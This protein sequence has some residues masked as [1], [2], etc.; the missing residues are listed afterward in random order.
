MKPIHKSTLLSQARKRPQIVIVAPSNQR[1]L[2][3]WN[4]GVKGT[5]RLAA[6]HERPS[7]FMFDMS[8]GRSYDLDRWLTSFQHYN[9][10]SETGRRVKFWQETDNV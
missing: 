8:D 7:K 4:T 1:P 5:V 6:M 2:T 10:N 3:M 9:C